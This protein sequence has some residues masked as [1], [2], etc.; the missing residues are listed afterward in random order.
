MNKLNLKNLCSRILLLGLLIVGTALPSS[1]QVYITEGNFDGLAPGPLNALSTPWSTSAFAAIVNTNFLSVNNSGRLAFNDNLVQ[2]TVNTAAGGASYH[3]SAW[4]AQGVGAT[5]AFSGSVVDLNNFTGYAMVATGA[6][7]QAST[8][9]I[10]NEY[11]AN[12]QT[13]APIGARISFTTNFGAGFWFVDDV[14]VTAVPELNP[15]GATT[16]VALMAGLLL[17]AFSRRRKNS[18]ALS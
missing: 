2:N 18:L 8:G 7:S 11:A 13:S 16:P 10:W 12:F 3:I 14:V 15:I 17:A 6:P 5:T 1:A 9:L 4:V